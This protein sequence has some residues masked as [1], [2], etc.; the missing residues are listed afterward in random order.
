MPGTASATREEFLSNR[1]RKYFLSA[2]LCPNF[3]Q[4]L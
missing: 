2:W 1:L 3:V 4:N